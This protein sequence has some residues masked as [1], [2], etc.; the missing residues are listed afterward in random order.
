MSDWAVG[1]FLVIKVIGF[2]N[3]LELDNFYC[4][5]FLVL[6]DFLGNALTISQMLMLSRCSGGWRLTSKS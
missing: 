2:T 5:P 6:D 1:P 4:K 3:H